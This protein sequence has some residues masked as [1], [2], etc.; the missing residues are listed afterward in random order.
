MNISK[1][2]KANNNLITEKTEKDS[3]LEII[4]KNLE[5]NLKEDQK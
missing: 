5:E 1:E 2:K 4:N 3:S